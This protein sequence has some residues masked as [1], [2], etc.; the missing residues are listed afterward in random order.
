MPD[1]TR[2]TNLEVTGEVKAKKTKLG[3]TQATYT[4]TST[5]AEEAASTAPTKAEF[6]AVA[7][8]ANELKSK[9]NKL[10]K[11]LATGSDT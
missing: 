2:L 8:L 6:D 10:V 9:L 3:L 4:V 1:Y 11:Q 7:A 5:D